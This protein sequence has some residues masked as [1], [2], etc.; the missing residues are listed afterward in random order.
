MQT[1]GMQMRCGLVRVVILALVF[2]CF[3]FQLSAPT[4]QAQDL[5]G[6]WR[7]Q[8][9]SQPNQKQLRE[10]RGPLR[11]RL[12]PT[13]PSTYDGRFSGRFAGVIPY[14]Y[15]A[16]VSQYGSTL[17][18]SKRLGPMGSYTMHLYPQSGNRYGGGWSA[19]SSRGRIHLRRVR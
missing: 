2:W 16:P 14:F 15:R 7:G 11:V 17:V 18:S 10:H 1:V 4:V 9:T 13:G 12:V 5:A 19:G 3:V 8:W 6:V